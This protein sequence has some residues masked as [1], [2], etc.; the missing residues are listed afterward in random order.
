MSLLSIILISLSP[1]WPCRLIQAILPGIMVKPVRGTQDHVEMIRFR[2]HFYTFGYACTC[3]FI[4]MNMVC[5]VITAVLQ[6][7]QRNLHASPDKECWARHKAVCAV[8]SVLGCLWNRE[9]CRSR[10]RDAYATVLD[11]RTTSVFL[12]AVSWPNLHVTLIINEKNSRA[13]RD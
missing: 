12:H 3:F 4:S 7:E 6:T 11:W 5:V 1:N 13:E 2:W 8:L 9:I 10:T